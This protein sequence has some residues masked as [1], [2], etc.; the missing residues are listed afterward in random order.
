MATETQKNFRKQMREIEKDAKNKDQEAFYSYIEKDHISGYYSKRKKKKVIISSI[1]I[2]SILIFIW[3]FYALSTWLNPI[4]HSIT[5]K[6]VPTTAPVLSF[7]TAKHKEVGGYLKQTKEIDLKLKEFIEYVNQ[8][9]NKGFENEESKY[10]YL[11][12][13]NS[14]EVKFKEMIA[15]LEEVT[16]PEEL[17]NYHTY[18]IQLLNYCVDM[19]F[20][21]FDIVNSNNPES[22]NKYYNLTTQFSSI[23]HNRRIDLIKVFNDIKM[24]YKILDDNTIKYMWE[25][26]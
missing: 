10:T 21:S 7:N 2:C 4:I 14:Y 3:N 19:I 23:S 25:K 13:L 11:N 8:S 9:L 24:E 22:I 17:K 5:N 18:T 12:T 20:Y 15:T 1:S 26:L 16:P 6:S